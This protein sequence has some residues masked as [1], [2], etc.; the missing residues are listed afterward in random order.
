MV[1]GQANRKLNRIA[2]KWRDLAERRRRYFVDE[3]YRSE[4]WKRYYTEA[5]YAALM[6]E[7]GA[8]ADLWA[9]IVPPAPAAPAAP[10]RAAAVAEPPAAAEGAKVTDGPGRSAA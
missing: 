6:E 5:E 8:A 3:F 4:R 10:S 1:D 2:A 7:A 9:K